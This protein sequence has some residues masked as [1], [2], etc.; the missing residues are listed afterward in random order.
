MGL[1]IDHL[2]N[3]HLMIRQGLSKLSSVSLEVDS[4]DKNRLDRFR[5]IINSLHV[6]VEL[7]H[8]AK[9]EQILFP[10]LYN[11]GKKLQSG[12][13]CSYFRQMSADWD[14]AKS[15]KSQAINSGLTFNVKRSDPFLNM[16]IEENSM[17]TIPLEEHVAGGAALKLIEKL[18]NENST[19]LRPVVYEYISLMNL[20][21]RKEDECLFVSASN[22]L[23]ND[24]QELMLV[25]A[26]KIEASLNRK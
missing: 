12:P 17:L 8:H 7:C 18:A 19:Y 13:H 23:S 3:E 10:K 1:F 25:E 9:E 26:L 5:L 14:Y 21:I 16:V 15:L 24:E 20:H 2:M 11:L 4:I 22:L 6:L